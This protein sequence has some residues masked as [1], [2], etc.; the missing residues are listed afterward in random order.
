MM[1]FEYFLKKGDVKKASIDKELAKSLIKDMKDRINKSLM[2]DAKVFSK[3]IFENIYDALRD[4]CDAILA[5]EGYKSYSHQASI[6][7][8]SKIHFNDVL[9]QEIDQFRQKRNDSKY[10][11]KSVSQEDAIRIKNFY[12]DNKEK[13]E[14]LIK[15]RGLE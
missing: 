12:L 11:G 9:I 13:F 3:M 1:Q 5:L 7:F 15:D 10:Y 14:K 8:L 6:V 4:F 2:L